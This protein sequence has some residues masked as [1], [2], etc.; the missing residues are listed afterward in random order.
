MLWWDTKSAAAVCYL[1]SKPRVTRVYKHT[2]VNKRGPCQWRQDHQSLR[3]VLACP[4]V[5]HLFSQLA[6]D[7]N[8]TRIPPNVSQQ[9]L[10]DNDSNQRA[11]SAVD[12]Q[13]INKQSDEASFGSVTTKEW[14]VVLVLCFVNLI[15]YM[16]RFT[17][18]GNV[19]SY[20]YLRFYL[21]KTSS[22]SS[23]RPSVL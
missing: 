4:F 13:S 23:A 11:G 16:D 2:S 6:A 17:V 12:S 9:H 20:D 10:M 5:L 7:M 1:L 19:C 15:N 18:S 8:V 21:A 3:V 14:L 22:F